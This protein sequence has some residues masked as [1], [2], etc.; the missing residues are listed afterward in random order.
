MARTNSEVVKECFARFSERDLKRFLALIHPEVSWHPANAALEGRE[1]Y[2]GH[3]G[4]RSWLEEVTRG[5][6]YLV[7]LTAPVADQRDRV[8]IPAVVNVETDRPSRKTEGT[9]VWYLFE[10][11]DGQVRRLQTFLDEE[12]ARAAFAAR[13]D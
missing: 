9:L 7:K 6:R 3:A 13:S 2:R 11:S 1:P 8:L 5:G 4:V 12:V 10:V